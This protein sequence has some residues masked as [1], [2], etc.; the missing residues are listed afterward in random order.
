MSIAEIGDACAEASDKTFWEV[1][2]VLRGVGVNV[3]SL[4]RDD[5][6]D[7]FGPGLEGEGERAGRVWPPRNLD[8]EEEDP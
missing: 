8:E 6:V 2:N 3:A 5:L 4:G 7:A 1:L